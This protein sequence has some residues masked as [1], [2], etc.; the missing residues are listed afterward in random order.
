MANSRGKPA[1][2]FWEPPRFG[3]AHK[4]I[5]SHRSDESWICRRHTKIL[6]LNFANLTHL[7]QDWYA[8]IRPLNW[9]NVPL[10]LLFT[11]DN[12][13]Q[14]GQILLVFGTFKA[15]QVQITKNFFNIVQFPPPDICFIFWNIHIFA[16]FG[17]M[18]PNVAWR[19]TSVGRSVVR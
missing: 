16:T 17:A 3:A 14:K 6:P 1:K 12:R 7:L 18:C 13:A 15:S 9:Q 8:D 19:R 5:Q 11:Q 10:R 4:N 2:I